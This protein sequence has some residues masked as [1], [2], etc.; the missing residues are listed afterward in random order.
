MQIT[1]GRLK[2]EGY[3]LDGKWEFDDGNEIKEF[4]Y[5]CHE[6][7]KCL[8]ELGKDGWRLVCAFGDREFVLEKI[9]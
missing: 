4:L 8:R 1:Y 7:I 3:Y 6:Y 5:G 9:Q 2:F